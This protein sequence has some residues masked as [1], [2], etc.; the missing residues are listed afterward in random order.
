MVVATTTDA[1]MVSWVATAM[2]DAANGLSGFCSSPASAATATAVSVETAVD[3]IVIV[4]A[5]AVVAATKLLPADSSA[6]QTG[7]F[8]GLLSYERPKTTLLYLQ[9][10]YNT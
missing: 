5:T 4:I 6:V 8:G 3:M 7:S 9:L 1:A 2:A 10:F